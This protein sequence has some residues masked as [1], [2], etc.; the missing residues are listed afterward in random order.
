MNVQ[1]HFSSS[2]ALRV[3]R[4]AEGLTEFEELEATVFMTN[5]PDGDIGDDNVNE[6]KGKPRVYNELEWRRPANNSGQ[7]LQKSGFEKQCLVEDF[8]EIVE[9]AGIETSPEVGQGPGAA[10][11]TGATS[12]AGVRVTFIRTVSLNLKEDMESLKELGVEWSDHLGVEWNDHESKSS[13]PVSP[14]ESDKP[15]FWS[16]GGSS[17]TGQTGNR[18]KDDVDDVDKRHAHVECNLFSVKLPHGTTAHVY[19]DRHGSTEMSTHDSSRNDFRAD[20]RIHD[21]DNHDV[22]RSSSHSS[23]AANTPRIIKIAL[24]KRRHPERPS[25]QIWFRRWKM[26][27]ERNSNKSSI[28]TPKNLFHHQKCKTESQLEAQSLKQSYSDSTTSSQLVGA[29]LTTASSSASPDLVDTILLGYSH[30]QDGAHAFVGDSGNHTLLPKMMHRT[31]VKLKE[32]LVEVGSW[33]FSDKHANSARN[34][35]ESDSIFLRLLTLPC[36]LQAMVRKPIVPKHDDLTRFIMQYHAED[37]LKDSK[38]T[39]DFG[40]GGAVGPASISSA[41]YSGYFAVNI[42]RKELY[43]SGTSRRNS[44]FGGVGVTV[45]VKGKV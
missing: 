37:K 2:L 28:P 42:G 14:T 1:T 24:F 17:V 9:D 10:S 44:D 26:N 23:H 20:T 36:E 33:L 25:S 35:D 34:A 43:L 19:V 22:S 18:N 40:G 7:S 6:V 8:Q 38:E 32:D 3:R 15:K 16:M 4:G 21:I 30:T 45:L 31:S 27:Q 29:G 39:H 12:E 11:G 5:R 13:G 41:P